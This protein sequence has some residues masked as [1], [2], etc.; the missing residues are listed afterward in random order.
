[1][2]NIIIASIILI[3][4]GCITQKR[5]QERYPCT[6]GT[7]SIIR[8]YTVF[9]PHDTI[10][11]I[12]ADSSYIEA[13]IDCRGKTARLMQI[14]QYGAGNKV[15]PPVLMIKDNIVRAECKFD[16][17]NIAFRYYEKHT[18]KFEKTSQTVIV[19]E[20]FITKGQGFWII[21][22]QIAAGIFA[23]VVLFFVARFFIKRY[24]GIKL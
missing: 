17:A 24:T 15:S 3:F 6:G 13:L 4:S 9:I 14:V 23:L 7:D 8:T 19:K 21:T 22:G 5:C 10:I 2:K 11:Q 20:N 18:D 12:P 16:S 1:M